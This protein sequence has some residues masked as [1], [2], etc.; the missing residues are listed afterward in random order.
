MPSSKQ[1]RQRQPAEVS[2]LQELANIPRE[3][4]AFG[5]T[6]QIRKFTLGPATQALQYVGALGWVFERLMALPRNAKGEIKAD[7]GALL[8]VAFE[9]LSVSGDAVMGLISVATQEPTEWLEGQDLMDG[10]EVFA[11]VLEKNA[12]FFSQ[13]NIERFKALFG[14]LQHSIPSPGGDTSTS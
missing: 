8:R 11:T 14:K 4:K 3:V 13:E 7:S 9:A 10:L 12:D 5:R 2:E 1:K 6:Y